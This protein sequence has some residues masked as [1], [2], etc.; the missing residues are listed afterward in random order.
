[1]LDPLIVVDLFAETY[2]LLHQHTSGV[3]HAASLR[4]PPGMT[5]CANW[6]IGHIVATR[7][8]VLVGLLEGPHAWDLAALM[9]YIPESAAIADE[10]G[11]GH[12]GEL[13]RE[14]ERSQNQLSAILAAV[15]PDVLQSVVGEQTLGGQLLFYHAHEAYHAG[16]LDVVCQFAR[17]ST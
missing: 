4:H 8:N 9:R 11:A 14:L 6:L 12:F 1:M 15:T 3:T 5:I 16:Q 17:A 10:S 13:L 7:A 2:A